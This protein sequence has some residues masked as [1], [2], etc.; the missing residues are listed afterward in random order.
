MVGSLSLAEH[1]GKIS[2]TERMA[3]LALRL[4]RPAREKPRGEA[5]RSE[6]R[7][8]PGRSPAKGT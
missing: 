3:E 1:V 7:G 4:T 8:E 6:Q 5:R 2:A